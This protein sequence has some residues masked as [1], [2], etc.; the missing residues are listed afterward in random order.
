MTR[1]QIIDTLKAYVCKIKFEKADGSI[2]DMICT[3]KNEY[4][5]VESAGTRVP[6]PEIITVWDIQKE[7]WRSFRLD[8]L[9]EGPA[10]VADT[11]RIV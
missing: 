8:R 9:I 1:E 11:A 3:L 10:V 4:I 5:L 2:R 6:N 7:A